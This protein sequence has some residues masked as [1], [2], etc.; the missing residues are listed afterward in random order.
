MGWYSTVKSAFYEALCATFGYDPDSAE[1]MNKFIPAYLEE[2]IKPQAPRNLDVCYYA[3]NNFQGDSGFDYIM[4]RQADK[5]GKTKTEI[6]K[7]VPCSVLTT[8]YGPNA[9]D[10]A[11][12][13]WSK[14]Q[15]D[16]GV[17]SPRAILRNYS[18]VPIGKPARPISLYEV[19]GTYQRRRSDVRVDLAYYDVSTYDSSEV[20]TPPEI[21]TVPQNNN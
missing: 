1:G 20:D 10:E 13:F 12:E 3:I 11:E 6:R 18:I 17:N 15:W 19:E 8:F 7:T 16:S 9:D 2:T 5:N 4:L 14:F 21:V